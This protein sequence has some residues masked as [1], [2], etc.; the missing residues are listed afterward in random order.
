MIIF[1][2]NTN[3]KIICFV[4]LKGSDLKTAVQQ[5]I[6]TYESFKR[7]LVNSK[8]K[9]NFINFTAKAYI[10]FGGSVPQELDKYKKEL[11]KVFGEHNFDLSRNEDLGDFIRG[12][13]QQP[14][15]KRKNR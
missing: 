9:S 2:A 5:V 11:N 4:E 12:V 7:Y 15:G 8:Q 3:D 1:Y 13:T 10:K 14:K 6:N